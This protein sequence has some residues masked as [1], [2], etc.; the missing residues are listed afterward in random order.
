MGHE[1]LLRGVSITEWCMG[2]LWQVT[3]TL[4]TYWAPALRPHRE[5]T[6]DP[7]DLSP[8]RTDFSVLRTASVWP[9]IL[10]CPDTA[11][12]LLSFEISV[13]CLTPKMAQVGMAIM[14][15]ILYWVL[16]TVCQAMCFIELLNLYNN[17]YYYNSCF[18]D[19]KTE[20]QRGLKSSKCQWWIF[21]PRLF[22][23]RN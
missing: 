14:I 4:F 3:S 23:S 13:L 6:A 1:S 12:A 22:D 15:A 17:K 2:V 10:P 21:K 16:T 11:K 20:D 9:V 7:Q 5:L 18:T 19:G 8:I